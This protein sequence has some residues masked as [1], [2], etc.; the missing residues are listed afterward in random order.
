MATLTW[1]GHGSAKLSH[2]DVVLYIDPFFPGDYTQPADVVLVTHNH[3]DHNQVELITQKPNCVVIAPEQA[4][5]DG[6][7]ID[8][9]ICGMRILAVQARNKNH[10]IDEC[11]GYV[12]TVDGIRIYFAGDTSTTDDMSRKLSGMGLDY[13]LLPIDGIYNMDAAEASDC[14]AEL[15]V[16]VA[17]PIHN[18]PNVNKT[19]VYSDLHFDVFTHP[20]KYIFGAFGES[21]ELTR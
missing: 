7:Y 21:L 9:E 15:H 3:F 6:A 12:V 18:D 1:I 2:G 20:G 13:A 14:A 19:H 5:Q 17:I 10:K 8:T 16:R 4:L 11:V